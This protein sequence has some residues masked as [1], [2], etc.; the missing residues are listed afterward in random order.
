MNIDG[1]L[2]GLV[3]YGASWVLWLLVALS[4]L[5]LAVVLERL[6][7]FA[8]TRGN[9]GALRA[10]LHQGLSGGDLE[11]FRQRLEASLSLEACIVGAGLRSISPREAEER[12]AAEAQLQRLRSERY[13][14]F[15]G[16]LGNNAPFVGLLGTVFG[17]IGAFAQLDASGGQLTTGLMAEI[18][19]ALVATAIGL[20]VALPAVA[21]YNA[22]QRTI[23]VRLQRGE[24][25]G[26]VFVAHLHASEVR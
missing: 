4:V 19:E 25:L 13:L 24:A 2:G 15:L 20:L 1:V 16:T 10:E 3:A 7:F 11:P 22:F 17:I 5:S 9:A 12:M 6:L 21:A 18:G 8:K 14:A 26:R 23:Q